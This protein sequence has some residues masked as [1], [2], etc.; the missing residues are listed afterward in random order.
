[1]ETIQ[2]VLGGK[3]TYL[4]NRTALR[5][6]SSDLESDIGYLLGGESRLDMNLEAVHTGKKTNSQMDAAGVLSGKAV[7]IFR[8]FR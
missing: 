2:L 5:G 1:M 8:P 3:D 7:K 4:R 6:E